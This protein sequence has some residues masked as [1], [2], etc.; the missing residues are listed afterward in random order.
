ML[1]DSLG[2]KMRKVGILVFNEV[3]ELDFAGPLEVFG[4]ASR[5]EY[6][7]LKPKCS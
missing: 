3:E 7:E 1:K 2:L 6:R 4:A 5:L